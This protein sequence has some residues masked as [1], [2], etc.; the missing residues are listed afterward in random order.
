MDNGA[1]YKLEFNGR[2][3]GKFGRAGKFP[4]EFGVVKFSLH[5]K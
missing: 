3:P 2:I 5:P 4:K 1:M